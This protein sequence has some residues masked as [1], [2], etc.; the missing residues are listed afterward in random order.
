MEH[1]LLFVDD[2]INVLKGINRLFIGTD[3]KV[4]IETDCEK[5]LQILRD[6]RI[7]V[8]VSDMRM[9]EMSGVKLINLAN[10]ID[11]VCIKII[12]SGYSD[13]EDIMSAINEGHIY[14]YITKPWHEAALK[15]LI[16]NSCDL[17]EKKIK[18]R[19]LIKKLQLK[20]KELT[21]LNKNLEKIVLER[22]KEIQETNLILNLII[23]GASE[24]D[25]FS[26]IAENLT[27]INNNNPA[28]V[29]V[30][31]KSDSTVY[32]DYSDINDT[33]TDLLRKTKSIINNDSIIALPL[34]FSDLLLGYLIFQKDNNINIEYLIKRISSFSSAAK[35]F[36]TQ[37][38]LVNNSK[39]MV[40]TFE[41]MIGD[42]S[43]D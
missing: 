24:K 6:N 38:H 16:S 27:R 37:K 12:L 41:K 21:D 1:K 15:L 20:Q 4:F 40:N 35:L 3:Y 23:K 13:I 28:S 31:D 39:D 19:I 30:I 32:G 14:S 33:L 11:Q 17:Y 25:V 18:E 8:M 10:E 42:L 9:P 34:L 29:L 36:M 5:A 7:S 22:T 2:E 43:D 26:K